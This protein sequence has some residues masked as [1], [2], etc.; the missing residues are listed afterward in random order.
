MRPVAIAFLL[1][2][3]CGCKQESGCT[4]FGSENY[5]PEAA[6]DDGS[7]IHIKD[8][9]LG[10]FEVTSDCFSEQEQLLITETSDDYILTISHLGDTLPPISAN[11]YGDNITID[12]QSVGIG[13][14]VEGAG[15][16]TD[17]AAVSLSYRIRDSRNGTVLITDCLDWCV[18]VE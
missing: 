4:K 11:V 3:A 15:V 17:E 7:C 14:T 1:F 18:K 2:L 16:Y 9:F 12:R 13:V 10:L 5:D 8:K 6:I